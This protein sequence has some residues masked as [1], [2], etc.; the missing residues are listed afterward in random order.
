MTN[1]F[2]GE[3]RLFPYGKTPE[4]WLPC[5]G[6]ALYVAEHPKLYMLIGTRFGGDG[7][8]KFKLPDLQKE[9][10]E[11]IMYCMAATGEFPEVWR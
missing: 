11:N 10:P 8:Q 4:G 5:T 1:M 2:L 6:Q 7:K 3:I 9:S